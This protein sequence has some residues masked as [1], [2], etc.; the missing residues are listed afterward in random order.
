[1]LRLTVVALALVTSMLTLHE[2]AF[3][4]ATLRAT[5]RIDTFACSCAEGLDS[6]IT[7]VTGTALIGN[8]RAN[9]VL[10]SLIVELQAR[11]N[12]VGMYQPIARQLLS[13]QGTDYPPARTVTTCKGPIS[14]GQVPGRIQLVDADENPLTFDDVKNIPRGVSPLNFVATFAGPLPDLKP[15]SRAR[16]KVYTTAIGT[17]QPPTCSVDADGDGTTDSEVKTLISQIVVRVPSTSFLLTP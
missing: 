13:G 3:A 9:P 10:A 1:M 4:C 12:G 11:K 5:G 8:A 6:P 17:D 16:L 15:G 14:S 7:V 2:R